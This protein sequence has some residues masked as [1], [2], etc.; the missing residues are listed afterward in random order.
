MEPS[1]KYK[2]SI[3]WPS[4]V[5][6]RNITLKNCLA[7]EKSVSI[8]Q[9]LNRKKEKT[10]ENYKTT[11]LEEQILEKFCNMGLVKL[12]SLAYFKEQTDKLHFI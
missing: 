9:H 1:N 8:I 7:F 6:P 5:Y 2:N 4:G 10:H 3:S 11:H 12:S